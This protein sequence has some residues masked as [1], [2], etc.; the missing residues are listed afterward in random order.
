MKNVIVTG[1]SRGIGRSIALELGKRGYR[2]LVNYNNSERDA[3]QVVEQINSTGRGEAIAYQANVASFEET[4]NM[5]E[6]FTSS[7]GPIY[8]LVANAGIYIRR[9]IYDMGIED[10]QK[11]M[12]INLN[13]AFYLVKAALPHMSSGSIVFVS[14]QLAFKGSSS[15]VAYSASKAGILGLMHSL[16]LQ[17]AP[18]IRVNAVAP[19][20]I[21]T[22]MISNYTPEQLNERAHEIPLGR[23]GRPEEV[24]E[25]VAFLISENSS[26]ITGA[27]IDVNG[28]LYMR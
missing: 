14:S 15:S 8:G 9:K 1:A 26:Y 19:G 25:V 10:W 22:D 2:V 6:D 20:T 11:T 24:A 21:E 3:L 28:G 4:R 27:T 5:I 13:G 23:I 17:L 7:F 18:G 12:D 16:A